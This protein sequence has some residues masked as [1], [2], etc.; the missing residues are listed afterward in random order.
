M[1]DTQDTTPDDDTAE[2]SVTTYRIHDEP[3]VETTDE[4]AAQ[5]ALELGYEVEEV[6]D[7]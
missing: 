6:T 1:T 2:C 5:A 4:E 7:E 3:V